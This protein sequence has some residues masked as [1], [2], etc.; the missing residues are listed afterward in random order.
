MKS[1]IKKEILKSH[2]KINI[3]KKTLF[4]D[5]DSIAEYIKEKYTEK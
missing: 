2:D 1:K 5:F 4:C 3:N